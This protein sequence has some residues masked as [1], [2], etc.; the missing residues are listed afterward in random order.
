[1]ASS[2]KPP[3]TADA[4]REASGDQ[5]RRRLP[6]APPPFLD[7][8]LDNPALTE[9]ELLLWLRNPQATTALLDRIGRQP[10]WTR[11]YAI[12][13][14]LV[15]H[16]N[17]RPAEARKLAEQLRW[18]ELL[19]TTRDS[20][21]HPAV[22][23]RAEQLLRGRLEGLTV[24]ERVNLAR[25]EPA[26]MLAELMDCPELQVLRGLL[27]NDALREIHAARLAAS[28]T[29][30]PEV[31]GSLGDHHAWGEVRSVRMALLR[32]DRTPV[33]AALTLLRRMTGRDLHR[34]S[35]DDKVPTIVRVGAGRELD[36]R[37]GGAAPSGGTG[38]GHG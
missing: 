10:R 5:L 17:T 30:P 13:R 25:S 2:P 31:L 33:P 18:R 28:A 38:P 24:G 9:R 26:G 34:L 22:R 4:G 37:A 15:L 8:A 36:R 27:S 3:P 6:F 12:R 7:G 23:R 16:P 1:V 19:E 35:G 21:L 14:A 32:N 20:R 29:A 11:T